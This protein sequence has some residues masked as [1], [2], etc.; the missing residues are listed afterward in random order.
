MDHESIVNLNSIDH[1]TE[2]LNKQRFHT[3]EYLNLPDLEFFHWCQHQY[4]INKGVYNTIDAWFYQQGVV[5]IL[6]RRIY[7][8]SFLNFVTEEFDHYGDDPK[9]LRF[10]NGGLSKKLQQF[11]KIIENQYIV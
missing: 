1:S 10:G 5:S 8:L 3:S 4:K 2:W 6:N 11:M 7:I 9:Y